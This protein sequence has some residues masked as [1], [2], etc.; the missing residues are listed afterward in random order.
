MSLPTFVLRRYEDETGVS[1]IG[2]VA[3]GI[4]FSDGTVAL[5]WM[6]SGPRSTGIY[7]SIADVEAIH[8]HEG[9]TKVVW[10]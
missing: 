6:T 1:G 3:E 2:V 10:L 9:K 4:E 5:H 7:N 8:G